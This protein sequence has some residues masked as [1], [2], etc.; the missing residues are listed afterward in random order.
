MKFQVLKLNTFKNHSKAQFRFEED[1]VVFHGPNGAGKTN[2]LD[3]IYLLCMCRSYFQHAELA[4][5][6]HEQDFYAV[7][8]KVL[9]DEEQEVAC[10]VKRGE[11]KTFRFNKEEYQRL[12]DHIG[13]MPVV[14]IA[15]GDI[16]LINE[17]SDE[18]R[19]FMDQLLSQTDQNY[20][21]ELIVYGRALE[22][23]NKA[24]KQFN[25]SGY[26]DHHLLDSLDHQLNKAATYL[27]G[28]R[29]A[30]VAEFSPLFE[31]HY[32]ELSQAKESTGLVYE[33]D[34]ADQNMEQ[35][36]KANRSKDLDI[37]RTDGGLHKDD[38]KFTLNGYAL[39]KFG[40]QGQ[41]KSFLI[42]LKLA[43]FDFLKVQKGFAPV[44]LLDDIFEKL[45]EQRATQLMARVAGTG[46][47]Q[48]F[49]SDTHPERVCR[50]FETLD[51][52]I[53]LIAL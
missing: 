7:F 21:Q 42:A 4:N 25:E 37:G 43:Q 10:M 36:L 46:Y 5:I 53:Q 39:K 22:H 9:F 12:S 3:A 33:S 27:Y 14:M 6:Q 17:Y 40:S 16:R 28:K 44:L 49:I 52:P 30:F 47:G 11:G 48:I 35:L 8:A 15:P 31:M 29:K 13:K 24:L 50:I 45:D 51:K 32:K 26:V 41:I 18:R 34:L 38:L 1:I 20:L 19:K 23:R 2:V